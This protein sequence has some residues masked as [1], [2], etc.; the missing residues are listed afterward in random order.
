M[1]YVVGDGEQPPTANNL[2]G[3]LKEKLPEYMMPTVFM[4]L[5][6]LPTMPNGKVDRKALPKPDWMRP[7]MQKRFVAPRDELEL[8]LTGLWEEVLGIRPIGVTDNFFGLG[9]HSLLAVRLFA[10]LDKRL[11]KTLPLAALFRGATVADLADIIRDRP[12]FAVPSSLVPISPTETSDP[13]S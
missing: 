11:G 2:R 7:E 8:Q 9:G 13:S 5:D 12:S 10:L 1:A 6:S 4:M 3:F